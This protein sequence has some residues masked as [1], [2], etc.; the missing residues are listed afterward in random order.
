MEKRADMKTKSKIFYL[1]LLSLLIGS[2]FP[3]SDSIGQEGVYTSPT[4]SFDIDP[5]TNFTVVSKA[6]LQWKQYRS[7]NITVTIKATGLAAGENISLILVSF[8]FNFPDDPLPHSSG[9]QVI[10]QNLTTI[11]QEYEFNKTF[12]PQEP[13]RFN[14]TIK[15]IANSTG[16]PIAQEF[17]AEFPGDE[18]YIEVEKSR[19]APIINLPGF[20][21]PQTFVRWIFIFIVAIVMISLPSIFVGVTK[22]SEITE[23]RKKKGDEKK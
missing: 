20:P 17:F 14:I 21:D 9:T 1:V 10:N 18:P 16:V 22:I 12:T 11:N 4:Y 3:I 5:D 19:A 15:V 8:L 23:K 13:E 7:E 2:V 6:P